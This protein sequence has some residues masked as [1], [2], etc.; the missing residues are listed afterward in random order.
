MRNIALYISYDGSAYHG[1]Q[2]QK[3]NISVAE[4]IED[5][6]GKICKHPCKLTG[7]GRTDAG[8]HAL[9]YCANFKTSC[10][11]PTERFP[12]AVNSRLPSDITVSNAVEAEESFNAI[13]SCR[14]KEYVYKLLC[15]RI[16][17]P[18]LRNRV[19]FFPSTLD[20]EKMK[21]ASAGFVGT[22]DFSAVRSTGSVT[23]SSV[24]TIYYCELTKDGELIT[25][26]ICADGFLYNMV[27]AIMGTI[28]YAGL[29]KL[30]P[31]DI[32]ALLRAGDRRLTGPTMPAHGLYLSRL[33]YEGEVG[34]MMSSDKY[35]TGFS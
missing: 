27:R 31:Q 22:Q 29:G 2:I 14:K 18:F 11:I 33:W 30:D 25:M 24:R 32:P 7:C 35:I 34:Q 13:S 9:S 12:F 17:N 10:S 3:N 28:V 1:W 20:F 4:T 16:A 21:A 19:C 8:V 15:S 6:L 26:S 5:A 23:K